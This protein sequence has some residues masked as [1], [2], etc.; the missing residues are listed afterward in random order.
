M[1]GEE[2]PLETEAFSPKPAGVENACT[3]HQTGPILDT[4]C[5]IRPDRKSQSLQRRSKIIVSL[6]G[7]SSS[8]QP[9]GLARPAFH[10]I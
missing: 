8:N 7:H 1:R 2:G 9:L 4:D 5:G 3:V 6:I 10:K